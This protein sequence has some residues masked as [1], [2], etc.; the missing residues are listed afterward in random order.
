MVKFRIRLIYFCLVAL[1]VFTVGGSLYLS[2]NNL[3]L[4][5]IPAPE[6]SNSYS[7]NDKLNFSRNKKASVLALGSSMTL[8]NIDSRVIINSMKTSDYLNFSSWGLNMHDIFE[9]V[10][11]YSSFSQPKTIILSTNMVDFLSDEKNYSSSELIDFLNEDFVL[12]YHL[13]HFNLKYY[14]EKSVYTKKV[15]S[16]TNFYESLVYD[17]W[18]G[19]LFDTTNFQKSAQRWNESYVKKGVINSNYLYFSKIATF[20]KDKKIQLFVFQ[21]PIREN[22]YKKVSH[23]ILNKHIGRLKKL[24]LKN[25]H[26]FVDATQAVWNDSLFVDG[27]H[28]NFMGADLYTRYCM[29][30]IM[31]RDIKVFHSK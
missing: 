20:C 9:L 13:S 12:G 17:K 29:N 24:T 18:G 4:N 2:Y 14:L 10:T 8:T 15:K 26:C 27:I 3:D 21:S 6:L 25:K 19:I 30:E 31:S 22:L 5:D 7:L 11:I 28:F 23:T 1:V 16:G